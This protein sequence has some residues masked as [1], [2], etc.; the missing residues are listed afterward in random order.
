[1]MMMMMMMTMTT[2]FHSQ[3]F[4]ESHKFS[5]FLT[6]PTAPSR[7][8]NFGKGRKIGGQ[9]YVECP[10]Q[11]AGIGGW[12]DGIWSLIHPKF[13]RCSQSA[14]CVLFQWKFQEPYIW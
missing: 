9:F 6:V 3:V 13:F 7:Y 5:L 4:L 14:E 1:M 8:Y 11:K 2:T 10:S 12:V